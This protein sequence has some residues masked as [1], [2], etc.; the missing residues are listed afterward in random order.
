MRPPFPYYGGK[1]T[2]A[3]PIAD[4]IPRHRHY[5][6]PFAGS[7]SVLLAKPAARFETVN[8]LHRELMTFWKVLRDNSTEL[9]RVCAL[10][11]HSRAEYAAAA[12]LDGGD[13]EIARRVWVRL[14]Q[15]R[16]ALLGKKTGWRYYISPGG[17]SSSMPDYLSGYVQRFA[18][19]ADRLHDVSLECRP[20]L[21]VIDA[22]G[23]CPDVCL[24]VDPPYLGSTRNG[25]NYAHELTSAAEHSELLDS[26]LRCRASV[27]LSGYASE[28]YD[29]ALAGWARV[30]IPSFNG[31]AVSGRRTEVVWSNREIEQPTLDFGSIG[32]QV[33][34]P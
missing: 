27:V 12:D 28:L 8:D 2:V 31:N 14:T 19:V 20:A 21:E 7:L 26:L 32:M 5:V 15:S 24:Y 30:E 9:A 10:T 4:L 11:P 18:A 16:S 17:S 23:P 3:A 6:E 29:T 1:M 34:R 13:M 25:T 22:Y 33:V